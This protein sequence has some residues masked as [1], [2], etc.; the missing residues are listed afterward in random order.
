[1]EVI[2]VNERGKE[3]LEV[4][5]E[6]EMKGFDPLKLLR[7]NLVEI[8]SKGKSKRGKNGKRKGD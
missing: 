8:E 2:Q 6:L 7:K 4:G 5:K 1:M 3:L